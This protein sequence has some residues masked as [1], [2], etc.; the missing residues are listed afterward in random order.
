MFYY[1]CY[2]CVF[3]LGYGNHQV[4][5]CL[6]TQCIDLINAILG[7]LYQ[8]SNSSKQRVWLDAYWGCC[9]HETNPNISPQWK[10]G[11][12]TSHVFPWIDL[13]FVSKLQCD[14]HVWRVIDRLLWFLRPEFKPREHSSLPWAIP[15]K[16]PLQG[17][18]NNRTVNVQSLYKLPQRLIFLPVL[19]CVM[20]RRRRRRGYRTSPDVMLQTPSRN[21]KSLPLGPPSSSRSKCKPQTHSLWRFPWQTMLIRSERQEC[22]SLSCRGTRT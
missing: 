1:C 5:K 9:G 10:K 20:G 2:C 19:F 3:D 15:T 13:L 16:L 17:L 7:C 8:I 11:V 6:C 12:Y 4:S 21:A 14:L 22:G 18:I